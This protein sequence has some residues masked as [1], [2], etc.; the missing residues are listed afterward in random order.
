MDTNKN[1]T[2]IMILGLI[3]LTIAG[4]IV[5]ALKGFK[6]TLMF[7]KHESIE[8]KVGKEINIDDIRKICDEI[9]ANKKYV[10]KELEVFGDSFQINIQ[11]ITDDEKTNLI[12]KVNEKFDT[13]KTVD[14]LRINSISNKRIR[15]VVK[16]YIV[17]M[18]ITF[19]IS[20]V[21]IGIRYRKNNSIKLILNIIKKIILTEMII[22]SIIAIT[23][24]P[25]DN[26]VIYIIMIIP[27]I[28]LI[29][30]MYNLEDKIEK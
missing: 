19:T 17:P 27:I 11:S 20:F 18:L 8:L 3:L 7:G 13:E 6:V 28:E 29:C 23:R 9:F 2:K 5:V 12:N 4:L 21:Y 16:P 10:L 24:I 30:K 15:D 14:D 25:V 26:N 1:A 22:L